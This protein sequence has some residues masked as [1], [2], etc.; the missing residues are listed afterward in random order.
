MHETF[1]LDSR[2]KSAGNMVYFQDFSTQNPAKRAA[3]RTVGLLPRAVRPDCKCSATGYSRS[4]LDTEQTEDVLLE[5]R[6]FPFIIIRSSEN[7]SSR[8]EM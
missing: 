7:H 1:W 2:R 8:I 5:G 4:G 3:H 6:G